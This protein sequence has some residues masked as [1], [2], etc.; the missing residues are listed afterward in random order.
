MDMLVSSAK[1]KPG[2]HQD[3]GCGIVDYWGWSLAWQSVELLTKEDG[4]RWQTVM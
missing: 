4:A 3:C 2:M 1:Y